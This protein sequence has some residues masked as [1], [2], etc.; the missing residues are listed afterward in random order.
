[1][2]I[3]RIAP[4]REQRKLRVAAYARVSTETEEQTE[5]YET[6]V[7]YYTRLIRQNANWEYVDVYADRK[8]A[9]SAQHRPEF[10]RMM[11]DGREKK[12]DILLVKAISRFAR[13]VVDAQHYVHEL[14]QY[15]VEVRF[16][17]ESISSADPTAEMMFNILAI[18]AQQES[19]NK[20]ENVRWT[21]Q[22]L[23][24]QGI[25]HIGNHRVLGYDEVK[26][27]LTPNGDA[28]IVKLLFEQ[29]A[30]GVSISRIIKN[31]DTAGAK[32]VRCD[33]PFNPAIIGYILKNEVY[34]GDRMLQKAAP[35]NYLTKKPD[36][37]QPYT[38]YYIK[39]DHEAIIGNDTWNKVQARLL[40][41]QDERLD[42]IHKRETAHFL[43]GKVFCSRCGAPY[44]RRTV[45]GKGGMQKVWKCLERLKGKNGNGCQAG[46]ISEDELLRLISERLGWEWTDADHFDVTTF[47]S[48]VKSV[49][50]T[51][52][53]IR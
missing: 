10:Q 33:Q 39:A 31:L 48:S 1:M 19:K 46:I 26:G 49:D 18:I 14:K 38:S 28:W 9:T 8:S 7:D 35:H 29:Y 6:Q 30:A 47:L 53:G 43:Y 11:A 13:N 2:I 36:I 12:F 51:E 23:A 50:I 4:E 3:R 45:R 41:T 52:K 34:R 5:S 24:E 32:R 42:G 27:K 16:E 15:D 44:T 17:N 22:K 25:R 37:T 20:S 21:Y 40:Q